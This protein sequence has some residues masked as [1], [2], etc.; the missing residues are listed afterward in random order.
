MSP[1]FRA[2]IHKVSTTEKC[3]LGQV[4]G[5]LRGRSAGRRGSS[6]C[7][8]NLPS[9]KRIAELTEYAS[10]QLDC[11]ACGQ[12][13]KRS[14]FSAVDRFF[15]G[16]FACRC[17]FSASV[18]ALCSPREREA[19]LQR[20][21][22]LGSTATPEGISLE[23]QPGSRA[24]PK[25]EPRGPRCD[26]CGT[27]L[28]VE[29]SDPHDRFFDI[30]LPCPC[31]RV[32]PENQ[33]DKRR[34]EPS[35]PTIPSLR[36]GQKVD[37]RELELHREFIR[38]QQQDCHEEPGFSG[39]PRG[40]IDWI[41]EPD[42][43]PPPDLDTMI[44]NRFYKPERGSR[45]SFGGPNFAVTKYCERNQEPDPEPEPLW[46]KRGYL[47]SQRIECPKAYLGLPR[48]MGRTEVRARKGLTE[49]PHEGLP[50][51]LHLSLCVSIDLARRQAD[52]LNSLGALYLQLLS[53]DKS[54]DSGAEQPIFF[55]HHYLAAVEH[56]AQRI[57]PLGLPES[58]Y[59]CLLSRTERLQE[60]GLAY[61]T[62]FLC[63]LSS[64][65]FVPGTCPDGCEKLRSLTE[66]SGLSKEMRHESLAISEEEQSILDLF[67]LA[68]NLE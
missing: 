24:E 51:G 61:L 6:D 49:S 46:A 25:K 42:D 16:H 23:P 66:V 67:F 50:R 57:H 38:S 41:D 30:V 68:Q 12:P 17:G 64:H 40:Y 31:P 54:E 52:I 5:E 26:R 65:Q 47:V 14:P 20:F 59:L 3:I 18:E 2:N 48:L 35:Q 60:A 1:E 33:G 8:V 32:E 13:M 28:K 19:A 9:S 7:R 53:L 63:E 43:E 15:A 37:Q 39:E 27:P 45:E 62:T 56:F 22:R 21:Y 11:P 36:R 44:M 34:P 58:P 4:A 29:Y 55:R 10:M